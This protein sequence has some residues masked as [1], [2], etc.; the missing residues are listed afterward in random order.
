[1]GT[2]RGSRVAFGGSPNAFLYSNF[3]GALNRFNVEKQ[4][5]RRE[6]FVIFVL[7]PRR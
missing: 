1:M 7:A 2:T 3:P 5:A 6:A 4:R